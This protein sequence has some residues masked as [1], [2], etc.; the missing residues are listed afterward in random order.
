MEHLPE[1]HQVV[2]ERRQ[3]PGLAGAQLGLGDVPLAQVDLGRQEPD[4]H[5]RVGGILQW[6]NIY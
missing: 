6:N 1:M 2:R 4:P 3:H 5:L